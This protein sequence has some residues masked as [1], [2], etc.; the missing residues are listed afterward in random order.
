MAVKSFTLFAKINDLY[1]LLIY[2]RVL[3]DYVNFH[4]IAFAAG[5]LILLFR[6]KI[7]KQ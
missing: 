7:G 4:L 6:G 1:R 3:L 2:F 5:K